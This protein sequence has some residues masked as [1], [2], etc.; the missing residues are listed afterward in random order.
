MKRYLPAVL[1]LYLA[2]PP[3]NGWSFT[4]RVLV[5]VGLALWLSLRLERP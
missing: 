5:A 1:A 2:F 4:L 3:W